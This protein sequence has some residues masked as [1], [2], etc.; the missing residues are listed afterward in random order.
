MTLKM[1]QIIDFPSFFTKVKSQKLPFKTSYKLTLLA[2]EIEKHINY[3]QE[4]VRNLLNEYGKKDNEGKLVPTTDG[5]GV[6][7]AE[8]TMNEAYAK[9]GELRELD[10]ELSDAKFSVDG[11]D[12]V[13][14]SPEEMIV[15]MPFIEA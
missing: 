4:Q 7:L 9:M 11:F 5:Q 3:Y 10:V 2:T 6:L 13:E 14:L 12:G 1:Y 15:I 8:E